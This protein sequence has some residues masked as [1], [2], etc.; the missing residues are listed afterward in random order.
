MAN[1]MGDTEEGRYLDWIK[2]LQNQHN[3]DFFE[4]QKWSGNSP[5]LNTCEHFCAVM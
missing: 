2:A 3:V 4:N 1:R 5:D